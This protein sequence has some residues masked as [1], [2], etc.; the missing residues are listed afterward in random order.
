MCGEP[1]REL[2]TPVFAVPHLPPVLG[3]HGSHRKLL[4]LSSQALLALGSPFFHVS[5]GR[6]GSKTIN[7]QNLY[8]FSSSL[9]HKEIFPI[10]T[11]TLLGLFSSCVF[12][13]YTF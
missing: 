1:R 4:G 8:F 11:C 2:G 7:A 10:F 3:S 13:L 9:K 6:E 12:L 5:H